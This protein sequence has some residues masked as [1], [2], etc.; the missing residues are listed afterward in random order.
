MS[1]PIREQESIHSY[2][3]RTLLC[4]GFLLGTAGLN[5]IISQHGF[6][7]GIPKLDRE[8]AVLFYHL[9]NQDLNNLLIKHAPIIRIPDGYL[10]KLA[11]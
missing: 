5:G 6:V 7:N 8:R 1:L 11:K 10:M 3:I 9:S 4:H 2:L